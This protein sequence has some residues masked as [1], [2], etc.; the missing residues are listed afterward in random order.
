M[1]N[2]QI[3]KLT[4]K[5]TSTVVDK[6]GQ[7]NQS[8]K[9]LKNEIPLIRSYH[10][11][12]K[13]EYISNPNHKNLLITNEFG[14]GST[15]E[16][17]NNKNENKSLINNYLD[18]IKSSTYNIGDE[19]N[20]ELCSKLIKDTYSH[21]NTMV[22]KTLHVLKEPSEASSDLIHDVGHSL[23][24][25]YS[26]V[27]DKS[28]REALNWYFSQLNFSPPKSLESASLQSQ[29]LMANQEELNTKLIDLAQEIKI[30]TD[31]LTVNITEELNKGLIDKMLNKFDLNTI[32]DTLVSHKLILGGASAFALGTTTFLFYKNPEIFFKWYDFLK[33]GSRSTI[34]QGSIK[35]GTTYKSVKQIE[36]ESIKSLE[37]A[38]TKD[39]IEKIVDRLFKNF[40]QFVFK[41]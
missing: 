4:A 20:K 32:L 24:Q 34:S 22:D 25:V 15:I 18:N 5:A 35:N 40:K 2:Q 29:R 16:K 39:L 41:K 3:I 10:Q 6:V 12:F 26:A 8:Q 1:N 30:K 36:R 11:D 37:T 27:G 28:K 19:S 33:S 23:V 9:E 21:D 7:T 31:K 13:N 38:S 17:F 14:D